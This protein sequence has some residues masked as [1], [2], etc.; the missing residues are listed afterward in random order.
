MKVKS[1]SIFF[2]IIFLILVSAYSFTGC[3][4]KEKI[5]A[6]VGDRSITVSEFKEQFIQRY[7]TEEAAQKQSFRERMDFLKQMSEREMKLVYAYQQGLDKNAEVSAAKEDAQKRFAIQ[8]K[9]YQI[10]IIDKH[11][12]PAGIREY[13]DQQG[14]EIHAKHI[15]IKIDARDTTVVSD[16]T[17]LAKADSL[18]QALK[19]GADWDA[20][21]KEFSDDKSNSENGGD[22]GYFSWGK[23]VDDFQ[24]AAF[25]LKTGEISHPVKTPYG[26]HLIQLVDHRKVEQGPFEEI[27]VQLKEELQRN[28]FQELRELADEYLANLKTDYNLVYHDDSLDSI[29]KKIEADNSPKN[30]SLFSSFNE[31]ERKAVAASY[32]GGQITVVDLDTTIKGYGDRITKAEDFHQVIDGIVIPLILTDR[33]KK[34]GAYDAPESVKA[35]VDAMEMMMLQL[36]EKQEI[37][38]KINYDDKSLKEYYAANLDKYLTE[39]QVVIREIMVDDKA[40]AD[41]LL[42]KA[43]SGENFEKLAKKHNTRTTTKKTNGEL[44]PFTKRQYGRIGRDSFELEAGQFC[45]QPVRMGK[46]YSVFELLKKIPAEQRTFE[47][48]R[49]S[50]E[51]D[52]KS[53]MVEK[54]REEW[55][56]KMTNE[57]PIQYYED[58]LRNCMPFTT[59]AVEPT[60]AEIQKEE[61]AAADKQ[62]EAKK[63]DK[64]EPAKKEKEAPK[65]GE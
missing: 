53:D 52:H 38:D 17:A 29:Y 22:L 28:K 20:I 26:Y 27:K 4:K 60:P 14:E 35:G 48:A 63:P 16:S 47:D 58:N 59:V 21:A 40:L 5:V 2:G 23:M 50:V 30:I 62:L 13:Y 6:K 24:K 41:D 11:I 37:E 31:D 32:D 44:G 19:A 54:Y 33:A 18:Y 61:N 46:N 34:R 7:R 10:E 36:I 57:V 12:T 15:L 42:R 49:A 1:P 56:A 25:A 51:R 55:V 65:S 9:L 43:K 64:K 45:K 3:A 8:Q 39:P